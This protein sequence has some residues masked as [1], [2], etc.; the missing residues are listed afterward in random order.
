MHAHTYTTRENKHKLKYA[1]TYIT[2]SHKLNETLLSEDMNVCSH[3]Y[4]LSL[5]TVYV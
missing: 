1:G 5:K 3:M 4:T 2:K